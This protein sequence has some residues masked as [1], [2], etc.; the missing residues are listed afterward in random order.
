MMNVLIVGD[1]KGSWQM[2]GVQLGRAIDARVVTRPTDID[3]KWSELVVL[4]KKHAAKFAPEVHKRGLPLI[5]DAL[6]FWQQPAENNAEKA[7]ALGLF[8]KHVQA[9][10]PS[11]VICATQ[12]MADHCGGV[13]LPHHTWENLTA[14]KLR[15]KVETVAYQGNPNC[16]GPWHGILA[17]AC[18]ARGWTFKMDPPDLHNVDVVV[19]LRS[20]AWNGWICRE[21]KSG[22]KLG[23]AIVAGRPVITQDS[24]AFREM[25]PVGCTIESEMDLESARNRYAE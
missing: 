3:W 25:N 1:G 18:K 7:Q 9:I 24:A 20:V 13:F 22:V 21:W 4:V 10:K 16:F 11:L 17:K 23:N 19:A 15:E 5:W 14:Q 6:D 2:R 12:A 8:Q